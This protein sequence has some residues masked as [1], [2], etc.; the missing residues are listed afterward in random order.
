M[1]SQ[2]YD[3]KDQNLQ[4]QSFV[5][6]DLT[7]A[8]F[9]G[10]DLRGCDF[11]RATLI[12]ANF[13]RST[14]GQTPQQI[15][16]AILSVIIGMI[17]MIVII[18]ILSFLI[19]TIDNLLFSWFGEIYR[20]IASILS[21]VF[22]FLLY[23]FQSVIMDGFPKISNFLG[24]AVIAGLTTIMLLLTLGFIGIS[25]SG[26]S[27]SILFLIAAV[28]SGMVTSK[29]FTWLMEAIKGGIGTS[30]KKA[31]LTG[32]NFSHALIYNTDFS[33]ALLTGICIEGWLVD[34]LTIFTKSQCEYLYWQSQQERYPQTGKFQDHE[35]EKFLQKFIKN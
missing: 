21:S 16:N 15:N 11:T 1:S 34:S 12:G 5:G 32:A 7:G 30:F 23:F 24:N 33:F 18:V 27:G 4:N 20:K 6:Q 17:V 26:G 2:T 35:W 28:I 9:S 22:L 14:T 13:E 19:V 25:F 29:L 31:N 3:Y 8:D 10:A